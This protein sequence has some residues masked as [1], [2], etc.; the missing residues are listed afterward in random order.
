M[1]KTDALVYLDFPY[2]HHR[3]LH[4]NNVQERCN[5]ELKRRANVVQVFPSK[6][7]LIRLLGA[8]FAE[9]DEDWSS[10]RWFTKDSIDLAIDDIKADVPRPT[11]TGS[12][13]EHAK[14][15]MELVIADNP[16]GRK[17]A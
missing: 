10:R 5:R 6:K 3:R 2:A 7:S 17:A 14:Q 12:A 11:Y 8:V 4:T 13:K 16:L 15:I 1:L 9:M